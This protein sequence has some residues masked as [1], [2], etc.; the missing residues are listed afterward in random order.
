MARRILN[1][2]N[3]LLNVVVF[4][5]LLVLGGYAGYALWDNGQ[6][7]Q[8]AENAQ[9]DLQRLRQ[10]AEA[11]AEG[12]TDFLA[13]MQAINED[14]KAWLTLNN[15]TIDYP[16][17]YGQT[18]FYYLNRD[19]YKSFAMY[20]S[21]FIDTRC[22]PTFEDRYTLVHGH[23][24]ANRL[25]FGDLD[26]YKDKTFFEENRTGTI[27]LPDR[28]YSLLTIACLITA[29]NETLIFEPTYWKDDIEEPLKYAKAIALHY[30]DVQIERLLQEN[31]EAKNGGKPPKIVVLATCSTEYDD[32]RTVLLAEMIEVQ[33]EEEKEEEI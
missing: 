7:Y 1:F 31:E 28:E 32:A 15:T 26:L 5:A 10:Q 25:M 6:I 24:I 19:V 16:L 3:G 20:G 9:A 14:V 12:E 30:D 13:E 11:E 27:I 17:L 4:V 23:H 22:D 21:I 33:P 29:A 18:N 8:S 2:C